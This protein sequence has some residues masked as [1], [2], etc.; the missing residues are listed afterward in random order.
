M[1]L[2]IEFAPRLLG[3]APPIQSPL[4]IFLPVTREPL[5]MRRAAAR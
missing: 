2:P 5:A 4:A 3:G 1:G